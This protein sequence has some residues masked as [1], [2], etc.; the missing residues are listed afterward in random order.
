MPEFLNAGF[1]NLIFAFP[2]RGNSLYHG[3]AAEFSRRFSQR[4]YCSRL[5]TLGAMPSTTVR[6]IST[7][8]HCPPPGLQD[9]QD[10]RSERSSSFL[11]RRHRFSFTTVYEVPW[12]RGSQNWNAKERRRQL[13][14][15]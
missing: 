3:L 11:D 4:V 15:E 1:E 9:F 2:N 7:Q 13:G 6:L 12:L 14:S 10:M 5:L 8:R